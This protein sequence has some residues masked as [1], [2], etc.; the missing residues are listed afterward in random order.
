MRVYLPENLL[1]RPDADLSDLTASTRTGAP[2]WDPD[3]ADVL[4]IPF[5]TDPPSSERD[6]IRRRLVT[7]DAADETRLTQMLE[8]AKNPLTPSYARTLLW[9]EL[10]SKYGETP[11]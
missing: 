6:A 5:S 11:A 2:F 8:D 10:A 7:R 9:A 4:V 1:R 3:A